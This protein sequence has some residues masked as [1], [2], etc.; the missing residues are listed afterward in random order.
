MNTKLTELEQL[1]NLIS[2]FKKEQ[3]ATKKHLIYLSLVEELLKL[4]K[5]VVFGFY[6]L[7]YMVTKDDLIQVGAIGA[8]KSIDTYEHEARGSFKTYAVRNIKGQILHYLRDK[9]NLVKAPRESVENINK[10]KNV[11]EATSENGKISIKEISK[12]VGLSEKKIEEIINIEFTKNVIS[13]DQYIYSTDGLETLLD[14]VQDNNSS[15]YEK[16]YETKKTLE[17][18]LAKLPESEKSVI[19]DYYINDISRGDI[20]KKINVSKTQVSRIIK[21]GLNRL[22]KIISENEKDN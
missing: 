8:L 22:Y 14:R 20:A 10:V 12:I 11:I 13:L 9:A 19:I 16:V 7:P 5:K 3:D 15:E 1:E 6:S 2:E 21:R 17:D 4:V 18:A